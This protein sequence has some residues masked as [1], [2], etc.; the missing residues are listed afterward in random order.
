MIGSWVAEEGD[1][2]DVAWLAGAEFGS[3]W[4]K[5]LVSSSF[6]VEKMWIDASETDREQFL[7]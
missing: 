1:G 4:P 3:S 5:V 2:L 6:W 7:F